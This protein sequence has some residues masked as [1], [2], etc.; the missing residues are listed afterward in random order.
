MRRILINTTPEETRI[1]VME[2]NALAEFLIERNQERGCVGNLY[3]G[4]V[5]R[6]LPGMQAAFVDIGLEKAAFLHASDVGSPSGGFPAT[7]SENGDEEL[8]ETQPDPSPQRIEEQLSPDQEILVQVAKDP[9]GMK[10][11]RV[12]THISLP[13]RFLVFMP[14]TRHVAVS[15]KIADDKERQRL[16]EI[17]QELAQEDEG[18]IVRTACE[19]RNKKDIQS[20]VRFLTKLWDRI[21]KQLDS[22]GTPELIHQDL[23]LVPRTIRD[24][25]NANTEEVVVD[26]PKEYRRVVEFVQQFMP[27]LK[28]RIALYEEPE[29]LLDRYEIERKIRKALEP[30]IWLNSGGHINIEQTEALTAVDV[31]TGRYVGK[32]DLE[33][34]VLKINLEATREVGHQLRLRN[35]GGII[36]IDFID[37]A[38]AA[39]RKKVY[40]ALKEAVKQD[41]ARTRVLPVSRL[42]LVEM[43]R[44]RTRENLGNLLLV[45]CP[46]CGGR[47]RVRSQPTIAYELLRDIKR[48]SALLAN[49]GRIT[50]HMHPGI[51]NFLYDQANEG[52]EALEREIDRQVIIKAD[53]ELHPEAY[54]IEGGRGGAAH[55]G[56][57]SASD[58]RR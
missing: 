5:G 9:L 33:A 37:M 20:D 50:V 2:D 8:L 40:E 38:Q 34:T 42:G 52:L 14:G 12:T 55:G 47:G 22:A 7:V 44:Q 25:F 41:K 11:A 35:V 29:P 17:V 4:R 26:Q 58:E 1:A 49:G 48:E 53:S 28:S 57:G 45:P 27:R 56:N 18:F 54:R 13:G 24:F 6:V 31:N 23:D 15:R 21:R 16:K 30:K 32:K 51:A 43:T 36:I 46:Q 3:K 19:G 39:N 10:G